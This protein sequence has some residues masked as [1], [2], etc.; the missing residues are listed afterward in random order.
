MSGIS[1]ARRLYAIVVAILLMLALA[2]CGEGDG[3]ASPVPATPS[4]AT[5]EMTANA[6]NASPT[7]ITSIRG[8]VL[9]LAGEAPAG[10]VFGIDR[11]DFGA[12]TTSL[13]HGDFNGD[14]LDDIL[15]GARFGDGPDNGRED[16][17]EAFVVFGRPEIAGDVDLADG[18]QDMTIYGREAGDDLGFSVLGADVN[19]DGT[20]DILVGAPAASGEEDPRTDQGQVYVFFGASDLS[21]V[22]DIAEEPQ[23]L[24][25]TGAEGFSRIGEAIAAGDVNGDG[26]KDIILGGPFA[27]REPG[28]PPGGPRTE[29]GEVY[30]ILGGPDLAGQVGLHRGLQ[31]LTISG[32][33]Q[34]GRFGTTVASADLNRDD[35]DDIIV[36]APQSDVSGDE[37]P[38]AGAVYVFFGAEG[39][40]GK[41][42]IADG[43]EDVLVLG[44]IESHGLGILLATGDFSGDGVDDLAIGARRAAQA[45]GLEGEE[46]PR[47]VMHVVFGRNDLAGTVDVAAGEEDVTIFSAET[48]SLLLTSLAGGDLNSDGVTD[49]ILGAGSAPGPVERPSAGLTFVLLGGPDLATLNL[50]A[51]RQSLAIV[52]MDSGDLLGAA[53]TAAKTGGGDR[54]QLILLASAADGEENARADSGEIYIVEVG[55][56]GG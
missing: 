29:V 20:D 2:A 42:S 50:S 21:G 24:T 31:D 1:L 23:A 55:S 25:I 40:S 8:P 6:V 37:R 4:T 54:P 38:A 35:I 17:G 16:G 12:G 48:P 11:G 49:L 15:A 56:L 26:I 22:F 41:L 47:R 18:Q 36:G 45:E 27:G 52:G 19:G 34:F 44:A 51:G 39:L 5:P 28:S 14:G 3:A 46:A 30:V 13:S 33:Q 7:P 43:A 53:V 9:D 32:S 10:T